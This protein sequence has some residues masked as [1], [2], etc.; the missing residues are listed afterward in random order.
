MKL[1][2][3][4]QIQ[5]SIN[6]TRNIEELISG[7]KAVFIDYSSGLYDVPVPMQ[8]IFSDQG[9]DCH[10]KGGYRQGSQYFVVKIAGSSQFGSNGA[11]LVFDVESCELKAILQ[12][13]GFLTTLRTAIAGMVVLQLMFWIPQNIGIIGSGSLA[14]QLY[15]LVRAKYPKA[16]M[17]LYARNKAAAAAIS[18]LV[19]DSAKD[20]VE[21]CDVVFTA[22]SSIE[23]IICAIPESRNTAIIGLGSDDEHKSEISPQLFK[24]ADMLIVDSKLQAEKFGDVARA[25]KSGLIAEGWLIEL[26]T[27][28][29]S[30]ISENINTIIADFSGIGA[31]D[32]AMAEF[33]LS[34]LVC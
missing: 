22:T 30:G 15:Q 5:E 27:L 26:G 28:L 29:K 21:K 23:P 11:I 34:R 33:V 31:Q 7:Q 24:A 20:L 3:L 13:K 8:F 16:N 6:I 10:I 32:V 12:D 18:D 19:C 1:F 4:N 17:L 25:L 9:S 2:H 14:R